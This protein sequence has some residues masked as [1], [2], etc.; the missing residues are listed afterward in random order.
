MKVLADATIID[1]AMATKIK[2]LLADPAVVKVMAEQ[3]DLDLDDN[4]KLYAALLLA[5]NMQIICA[6]YSCVCAAH[7]ALC[8]RRQLSG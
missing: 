7:G 4:A 8:P 1:V 5:Y 2:D 3:K 6:S